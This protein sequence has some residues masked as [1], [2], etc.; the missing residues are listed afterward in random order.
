[1]KRVRP[2]APAHC[3]NNLNGRHCCSLLATVPCEVTCTC[4]G[5]LACMCMRVCESVHAWEKNKMLL[6]TVTLR[7]PLNALHKPVVSVPGN[8]YLYPVTQC[9]YMSSNLGYLWPF[10]A[11]QSYS[12]GARA[13]MRALS[14]LQSH[15]CTR[16]QCLHNH[17]AHTCVAQMPLMKSTGACAHTGRGPFEV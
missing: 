3:P 5:M 11:A 10:D 1:M 17:M 16:V 12:L 14:H 15:T 2:K 7:M 8:L 13:A 6:R 9:M 4:T